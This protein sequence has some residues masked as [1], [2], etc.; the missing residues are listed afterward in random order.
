MGVI[1][2]VGEVIFSGIL[3][4]QFSV[5]HGVSSSHSVNLLVNLSSVMVALLCSSGHGELNPYDSS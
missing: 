4:N 1:R 3:L 5:F 2:L